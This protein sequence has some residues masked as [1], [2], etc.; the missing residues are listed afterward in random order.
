MNI[1]Y[2]RDMT[3]NYMVPEMPEEIREDDY[4]VHMLMENHIQGLLPCTLKRIN[5]Q[6]RFYYDI[7]SRQSMERIYINNRMCAKDIA[8][9]L[10]G[11]YRALKEI[12]KYL[13]DEDQ[14]VLEP[15]MIY[16]DIETQE[17]LFCYLPGYQKDIV[18]S[19][20]ELSAYLLEHLDRADSRA[21]L[22]GFEIYQKARE[23]NY[24]LGKILQ[25]AEQY[26]IAQDGAN[27]AL[28]E[29]GTEP[30]SYN[31]RQETEMPESGNR[32]AGRARKE[33]R[34]GRTKESFPQDDYDWKNG[35]RQ[36]GRARKEDHIGR[37]KES[38]PQDDYDW[39]NGNRQAGRARKEDH[40]GR[41]KENFPQDGYDWK[42][43]NR[44]AENAG[45]Q[46]ENMEFSEEWE[47]DMGYAGLRQPEG[48]EKS[49]KPQKPAKKKKMEQKKKKK[50]DRSTKKE[51]QDTAKT[52]HTSGRVF[53]ILCF[54]M[55]VLLL[56]AAAWFWK[57]SVTQT[58]GIVFLLVGILIYGFSMEGKSAKAKEKKE[59]KESERILE[60]FQEEPYYEEPTYDRNNRREREPY[61]R[62]RDEGEMAYGRA[63]DE[64]EM[65]YG[66][67]R[68]KGEM[69]YGRARDKG[70]MAYGR[71][72]DKG[73]MAYGRA[74][75][76]EEMT[77]G[78]QPRGKDA[79]FEE[80]DLGQPEYLTERTRYENYPYGTAGTAEQERRAERAARLGNTGVLYED[81]DFE[82]HL[83]LVN[84]NPKQRDSIILEEESYIVGKLDSRCDIVID[85]PSVSRVHAKLER[86]GKMYF[87]CDLNSTN[88][89]F[90]NGKRLMVNERVV[91]H[92]GDEIAFARVGY[93]VR[94]C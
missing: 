90:L 37:T 45:R 58:G 36:A 35:N 63:R 14:I 38:F 64:N 60:D 47:D 82:Q 57:L 7:T 20:R 16:M 74:R 61:G 55:A 24:S 51:P 48:A 72:R 83:V 41:T 23:E 26:L 29:N 77:Y 33:D 76:N 93:Y 52:K 94:R 43:G 40:I 39:K 12:K 79:R 87:L 84:R 68:D 15:G 92:P 8:A 32:Q 11:L 86:Q 1:S 73:E 21:V 56:L 27:D 50:Q 85:H 88:G 28:P 30:A 71:A 59:K 2:K 70:E 19:F 49:R 31:W 18:Q 44:Q 10:R 42:D 5:G 6:G 66:R 78:R 69:A 13:L 75:D 9:L 67:T 80:P 89:T 25:E 65:A 17:P 4:R 3:H 54:V 91:I 22:L 62:A 46:W 53:L 81:S 34:V